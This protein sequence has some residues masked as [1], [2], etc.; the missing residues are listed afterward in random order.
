MVW[1]IPEERMR[2]KHEHWIPLSKR[3]LEVLRAAERLRPSPQPHELVFT[4][5]G[6]RQIDASVLSK[7]CSSAGGT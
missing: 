6:G 1:T 5:I 2:A 3:A 4:S 7:T